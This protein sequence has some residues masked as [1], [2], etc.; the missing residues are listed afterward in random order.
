MTLRESLDR[1]F[2][3][4]NDLNG[5]LHHLDVQLRF[6]RDNTRQ[7]IADGELRAT[8]FAAGSSLVIRDLTEKPS[9]G[10]PVYFP[11]GGFASEGAEF[12]AFA[13]ELVV[14]NAGWAL[15]QGFERFESGLKDLL[16]AYYLANPSDVV[17][18]DFKRCAQS[19][20][21]SGLSSSSFDFWSRFVR[22]YRSADAVLAVLRTLAAT[23]VAAE[24]DN[25][26]REDLRPWLKVVAE[27]RHAVTHSNL[28]I[29]RLKW[30]RLAPQERAILEQLVAGT[31][32]PDGF[33]LRPTVKQASAIL[34][35]FV[36][37]GYAAY[38]ALCIREGR[39]WRL[40]E[41]QGTQ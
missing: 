9:N 22:S 26:Y 4:M 27:A 36:E 25:S 32:T 12:I 16:A 3:R 37:Y 33:V 28:V 39:D 29:S 2:G 24:T 17:A 21:K 19:L 13:D 6:F 7:R 34:A 40:F 31:L 41:G 20:Q 18:T 11:S 10:Y 30:D 14:R 38:K 8:Q 15:A 5:W 1:F 23:L 35:R